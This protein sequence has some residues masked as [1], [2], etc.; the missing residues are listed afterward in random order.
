M[1]E[2]FAFDCGV[3]MRSVHKFG[4]GH[5]FAGAAS[6]PLMARGC[7]AGDRRCVAGSGIVSIAGG[8]ALRCECQPSLRV[9]QAL[10]SR[11]GRTGGSSTGAGDGNAGSA[12]CE[13]AG[14]LE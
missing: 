11:I 5:K 12:D 1:I 7:E 9:A 6:A 2:A 13:R 3:V 4:Y 10:P 14:A 8:A